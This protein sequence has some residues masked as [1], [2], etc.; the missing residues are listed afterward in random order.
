MCQTG[1]TTTCGQ[2]SLSKTRKMYLLD[3]RSGISRNDH[4]R[5][6]IMNGP[7]Q[8]LRDSGMACANKHQKCQII[9]RIWKLLLPVHTRLWEYHKTAKQ[10]SWQKQDI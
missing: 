4:F 6:S 2:R 8:T 3:E 1:S 10:S 9:P 7:S 5:K